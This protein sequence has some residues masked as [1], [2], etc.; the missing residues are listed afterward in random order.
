MRGSRGLEFEEGRFRAKGEGAGLYGSGF[1]VF[2][3]RFGC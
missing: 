2:F 3:S 1:S